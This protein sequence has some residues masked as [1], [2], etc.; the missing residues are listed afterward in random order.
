MAAARP[1]AR[2]G[3]LLYSSRTQINDAHDPFTVKIGSEDT[4]FAI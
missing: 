3:S 2:R 1:C 4:E